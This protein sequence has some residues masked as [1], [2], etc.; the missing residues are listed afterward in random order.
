MRIRTCQKIIKQL[1]NTT[2]SVN[3][4]LENFKFGKAAHT[5]YDFFWHDFCDNC[6]EQA[7][8]RE[9]KEQIAKVL[10][11]VLKNSLI[12]FHPFIPFITEEI[13]QKL[14]ITGKKECLMIEEWPQG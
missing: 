4:D 13:Y 12:L 14:P 6:L 11:Y 10:L 1:E 2:K 9:D 5:L 8:N 7:K 3:K